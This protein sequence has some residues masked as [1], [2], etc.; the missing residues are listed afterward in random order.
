MFRVR[1]GT[2]AKVGTP[3]LPGPDWK[4]GLEKD[5]VQEEMQPGPFQPLNPPA[6]L[7]LDL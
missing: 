4:A 6:N 5:P 1:A 3:A 7:M 2:L